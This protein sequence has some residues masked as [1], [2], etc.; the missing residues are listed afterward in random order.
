MLIKLTERQVMLKRAAR[1]FAEEHLQPLA[2]EYD[3]RQE[4]PMDLLKLMGRL[5]YLGLTAPLK[6]GGAG[7]ENDT[8]AVCLVIEELS[9]VDAAIGFIAAVQNATA[10]SPLNALGTEEQKERYLAPM[11]RGEKFGALA[12]TEANAGSD[13]ASMETRAVADGDAYILNGQKIF[14]TNGGFADVIIVAAATE[15]S[16][17]RKKL[18]LFIVEKE[19]PG[20]K[21]GA[22]EDK[23]GVRASATNEILLQDCRVPKK[24]ILGGLNAGMG[25]AL[26]TLELGRTLIAAQCVGICQAS[27]E[28]SVQYCNERAQFGQKIG[29]F[30]MN[31]VKLADMATQTEAARLLT[32]EAA[33][34]KD[35]GLPFGIASSMAKLYASEAAM[36]ASHQ[37]VQIHGGYGL[38]KAYPLE[39]YFRDAKMAEIYEG[40]SEVQR[41]IIAGAVL[42]G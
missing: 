1:Q 42:K 40:T 30:Q 13:V 2:A 7:L 15:R 9:G 10:V 31:Q 19:N 35:Q 26:S 34:L 17:K 39:R 11:A 6:Y 41:M 29:Q 16:G 20:F 25:L 14:I 23:L 38:M 24:N 3:R 8:V 37:A 32:F 28:A 18:T 21:V 5:K 4:T 27:L 36:R 12:I 33:S 22:K